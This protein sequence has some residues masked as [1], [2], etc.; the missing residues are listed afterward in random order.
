MGEQAAAVWKEVKRM[1][2]CAG[3]RGCVVRP[4]VLEPGTFL[5]EE[6]ALE[7]SLV[8]ED[9]VLGELL[10]DNGVEYLIYDAAS[11]SMFGVRISEPK[12]DRSEKPRSSATMM[13]KFG[14]FGAMLLSEQDIKLDS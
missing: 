3:G 4:A 9:G 2:L 1:P 11:E 7:A 13:R 8:D 12:E 6:L 14:R 5:S 10:Q